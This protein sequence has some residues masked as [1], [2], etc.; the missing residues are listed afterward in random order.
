MRDTGS[1]AADQLDAMLG[2]LDGPKI[3]LSEPGVLADD[4]G[5]DVVAEQ[6]E[7]RVLCLLLDFAA[8][9]IGAVERLL[10]LKLSL[11][12]CG[13]DRCSD[14]LLQARA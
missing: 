5:D 3:Q 13:A 10:Q 14:A 8:F 11:C 1:A 7:Q 9:R 4:G 6:R 2:D 12:A